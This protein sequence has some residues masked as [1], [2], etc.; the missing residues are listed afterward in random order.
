MTPKTIV[1]DLS[2]P[3]ARERP[4]IAAVEL[5]ERYAAELFGVSARPSSLMAPIVSNTNDLAAAVEAGARDSMTNEQAFFA[6]CN[7]HGVVGHWREVE[8]SRVS[9]LTRAS[10]YADLVVLH[11]QPELAPANRNL[12]DLPERLVL[13]SA[14]PMLIM[15]EGGATST[16]PERALIAWKDCKEAARAVREAVPLLRETAGVYLLTVGEPP[17]DAIFGLLQRHGII[18]HPKHIKSSGASVAQTLLSEAKELGCSLLVMGAYGHWRMQE[19][20]FGGVTQELFR[21]AHLPI[22]ASH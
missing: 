15:P 8:D 18:V 12:D 13:A 2:W 6:A 5:A 11:Q 9:L 14:C 19:L 4:L 3:S 16:R 21:D 22:F 10:W 1:V 20:I 7:T 17:A